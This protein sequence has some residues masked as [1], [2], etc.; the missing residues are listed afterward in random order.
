MLTAIKK[1]WSLHL[2]ADGV[3]FIFI[4]LSAEFFLSSIAVDIL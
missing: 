2:V 4:S 3:C 1:L